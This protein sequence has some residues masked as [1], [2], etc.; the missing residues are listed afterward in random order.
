LKEKIFNFI[1]KNKI[2]NIIKTILY[3]RRASGGIIIPDFKLYYRVIVRK[4]SW[5]FY[6]SREFYQRS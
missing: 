5:Y 4:T 1:W 3:D 6:K 2:V